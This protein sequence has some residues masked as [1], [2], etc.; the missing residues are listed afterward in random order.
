MPLCS[1]GSACPWVPAAFGKPIHTTCSHS[2]CNLVILCIS[3]PH[4]LAAII[5]PFDLFGRA[6]VLLSA[7]VALP[8]MYKKELS[9]AAFVFWFIFINAVDSHRRG[10]EKWATGSV[11][12]SL[13]ITVMCL[14][15]QFLVVCPKSFAGTQMMGLLQLPLGD[16]A[17]GKQR[18]FYW[19]STD[20][21]LLL[22]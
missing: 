3:L 22:I 8:L 6:F 1:S 20:L 15:P 18:G 12:P 5:S 10:R 2:L 9:S 4:A 17:T 19:Y 14:K 13:N 21:F 11:I 7:A 16:D